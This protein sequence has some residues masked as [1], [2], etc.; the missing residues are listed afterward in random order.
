MNYPSCYLIRFVLCLIAICSYA[1]GHAQTVLISDNFD[2]TAPPRPAAAALNQQ[3]N[4]FDPITGPSSW[5][6]NVGPGGVRFNDNA[7]QTVIYT[8]DTIGRRASLGFTYNPI[9]EHRLTMS[10]VSTPKATP[11]GWLGGGFNSSSALGSSL[12]ANGQVWMNINAFGIIT[13]R[14]NGGSTLIGSYTSGVDWTPSGGAFEEFSITV[15]TLAN[16]ASGTVNGTTL[17]SN[18]S[19]GA[20][21][22]NINA[23]TLEFNQPDGIT[24][25][26][27]NSVEVVGIPEPTTTAIFTLGLGLALLLQFRRKKSTPHS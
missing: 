11:G 8:P 9:L 17:F 21:T 12:T 20:F 16:T 23:A 27:F 25:E 13:A 5:N 3:I 7:G 6:A 4:G 26:S 22:P 10:W 14:A 18:I 19:L 15:D 24:G 2:R 1:T